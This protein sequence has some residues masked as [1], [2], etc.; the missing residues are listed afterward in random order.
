MSDLH[1]DIDPACDISGY[2]CAA[3]EERE[4]GITSC[5][6]CGKELHYIEGRWL[7]WD[8]QSHPNPRAQNEE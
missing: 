4:R 8:W 2:C 6:Y 1:Q 3:A 7:T 5:I